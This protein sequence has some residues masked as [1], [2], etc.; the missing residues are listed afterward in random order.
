MRFVWF[1]FGVFHVFR[2]AGQ[3]AS[4]AVSLFLD[5]D[6]SF[7]PDNSFPSHIQLLKV[8]IFEFAAL[9]NV[10]VAFKVVTEACNVPPEA[11]GGILEPVPDGLSAHGM[12]VLVTSQRESPLQ[13]LK[14][15]C[16]WGCT[17][18]AVCPHVGGGASD[19]SPAV[20]AGGDELH[21]QPPT[22]VHLSGKVLRRPG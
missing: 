21:L 13:H 6:V 17:L 11:A 3:T 12:C 20:T 14:H 15:F 7:L 16:H 18:S 22:V 2:L 10:T 8:C 9:F 19:G 1:P 5:G 4:R